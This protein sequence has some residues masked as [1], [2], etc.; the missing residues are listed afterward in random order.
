M[1]EEDYTDSRDTSIDPALLLRHGCNTTFNAAKAI[2]GR[3]TIT[4]RG[5]IVTKY[6]PLANYHYSEDQISKAAAL[7]DVFGQFYFK[8][9]TLDREQIEHQLEALKDVPVAKSFANHLSDPFTSPEA[10]YPFA[11]LLVSMR[12][13]PEAWD[14]MIRDHSGLPPH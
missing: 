14:K 5:N 13:H 11:S 1:S 3:E 12:A 9:G 6:E 4:V 7:K 10:T 8:K 2:A